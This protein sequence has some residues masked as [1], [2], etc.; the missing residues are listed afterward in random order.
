MASRVVSTLGLWL[1]VIA[2]LWWAGPPGGTFL[3][4]LLASASHWELGILLR[5]LDYRPHQR[6]GVAFGLFIVLGSYF[7]PAWTHILHFN[8]G[9]DLLIVAVIL[10]ALRS[11]FQ[12][13]TIS[14]LRS[15][16]PTLFAILLVPYTLQFLV[17]LFWL[18]QTLGASGQ[19]WAKLESTGMLMSIWVVAV[20]KF[21]DVGAL[22]GGMAF[23]KHPF[24]PHLSPKKTW[25]GVFGGILTGMMVGVAFRLLAQE[26]LPPSFN[27]VRA[28][29]MALLV[30]VAGIAGD[31]LESAIKREAGVKDSGN[32]IPG[33]GGALDLTD[34]LILSAP[35]AYFLF[36]YL[37]FS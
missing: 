1:A 12:A 3:L 30:A 27:T 32:L 33:I 2:L 5:R 20:V 35:L 10:C 34:S 29:L 21:C 15:L 36:K 6:L 14:Y 31:L 23:G 25:E 4:A 28:A 9:T 13:G 16:M 19:S 8:S 24:S 22:L 17:A 11:L 26:A 7:L 37:V 18:P